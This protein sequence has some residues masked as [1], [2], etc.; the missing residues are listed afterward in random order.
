MFVET[1]TSNLN[2]G[3]PRTEEKTEA[4]VK[5]IVKELG[6]LTLAITIAGTYVAQTPRLLSNLPAHLEDYRQ[7]R[8]ELLDEQ[9]DELIHE[10]G[11][12]AMTV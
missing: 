8:Q 12:S 4:E 11:Y 3:F 6:C 5:A 2:T 7:R 1:P 9:L 10:Y